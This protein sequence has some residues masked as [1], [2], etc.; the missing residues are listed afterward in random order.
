MIAPPILIPLVTSSAGAL[1]VAISMVL[2]GLLVAMCGGAW[3]IYRLLGWCWSH[4]YHVTEEIDCKEGD[5]A[6]WSVVCC[7]CGR[8]RRVEE[9]ACW[10]G[11]P[12]KESD[13]VWPYRDGG[14]YL[15]SRA[16]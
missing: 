4:H 5:S 12:F 3:L 10:V 1:G 9:R 6:Y 13:V 16:R 14:K 11:L 2:C 8:T 7:R 15:R